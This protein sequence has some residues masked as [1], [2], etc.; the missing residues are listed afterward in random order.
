MGGHDRLGVP[1]TR[2]RPR[3][4]GLDAGTILAPACGTRSPAGSASRGEAGSRAPA[5]PLWPTRRRERTGLRKTPPTR[6]PAPT[7]TAHLSAR[8][9]PRP[10]PGLRF[11]GVDSIFTRAWPGCKFLVQRPAIGS[12]TSTRMRRRD[13]SS[14]RLLDGRDKGLE[15]CPMPCPYPYDTFRYPPT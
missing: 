11:R 4:S 1:L 15:T 7:D 12:P 8:M 10:F 5:V 2:K 9:L 13:G 14:K 6:G 3:L